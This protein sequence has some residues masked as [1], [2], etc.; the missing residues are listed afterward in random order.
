MSV[1]GVNIAVQCYNYTLEYITL[2]LQSTVS[3]I[4]K[5][6]CKTTFVKLTKHFLE[7]ANADDNHPELEMLVEE[8]GQIQE[9]EPYFAIKYILK[10]LEMEDL[11]P[12]FT[13]HEIQVFHFLY[14]FLLILT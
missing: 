7:E 13:K 5:K 10:T 4:E 2:N 14:L 11:L 12:I 1:S 8:E 3:N 9:E 6:L